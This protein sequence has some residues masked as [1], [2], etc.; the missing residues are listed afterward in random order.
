MPGGISAE[1]HQNLGWLNHF[2][3]RLACEY[4]CRAANRRRASVNIRETVLR[5]P[6]GT[7]KGR[8]DPAP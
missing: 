4:W 8:M 7:D 2:R 1:L 6:T 3:A 5:G